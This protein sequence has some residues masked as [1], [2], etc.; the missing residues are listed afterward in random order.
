GEMAQETANWLA[1]A[2]GAELLNGILANVNQ[3][4]N[5]MKPGLRDIGLGFME[6]ANQAAAFDVLSGAINAFG[7][8]FRANLSSLMDGRLQAALVGL[9]GVLS[10]TARGF[11]DLVHNGIR[12]FAEAAPGVER[13]IN[14]LREFF[15]RFDWE[16][17]GRAV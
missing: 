5:D 10:E 6:L 9:R 15:N 12:L 13:F 4:L 8:S 11:S 14:K 7:E 1:T 2:Q 17:L 3:T 16:R